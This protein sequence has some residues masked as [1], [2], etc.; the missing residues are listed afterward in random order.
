MS[1]LIYQPLGNNW[2]IG[3]ESDN[4]KEI[5]SQD[6]SWY[7]HGAYNGTLKFMSPRFAYIWSTEED[8]LKYLYNSSLAILLGKYGNSL[9]EK[10]RR[11]A[12]LLAR[13]RFN[14]YK[15]ECFIRKSNV[16]TYRYVPQEDTS[17][18]K[19]STQGYTNDEEEWKQNSNSYYVYDR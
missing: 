2:A 7:N 1:K 3:I 13:M 18:A 9:K 14:G 15:Q 6:F 17:G 5:E 4:P 10:V 16:P 8:F 12:R 11:Y 19:M